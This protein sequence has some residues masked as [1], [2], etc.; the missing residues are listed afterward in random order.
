MR[1]LIHQGHNTLPKS[2][3]D[4]TQFPANKI[5]HSIRSLNICRKKARKK[6]EWLES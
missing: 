4:F 1:K 2:L 5:V 6:S 3:Q